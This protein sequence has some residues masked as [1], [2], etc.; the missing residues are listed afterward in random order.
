MTAAYSDKA[1]LRGEPSYVWRAGQERR[2]AM[3]LEAAGERATGRVL[4]NGCGV[5]MYLSRLAQRASLAAGI[6]YEHERALQARGLASGVACAAGEALPF[7]PDSFDLILSHEV[8]EHVQDDFRA[9][10]EMVR[11]LRPGGRLVLFVP[12]RGYPFETH[13][14]YWRGRYRFGNIPLVNYLPRRLRDKLAPHV[15]VYTRRDLEKRFAGLPVRIIRRTIIFGAYDNIIARFPALGRLVRSLLHF[16]ERTPLRIFGLSHFWV[17][18]K[19]DPV[20]ITPEAR[21]AMNPLG[22]WTRI[23]SIGL[24]V[25]GALLLMLALFGG[26]AANLALPL[27]IVVLGAVFILLAVVL[28]DTWRAAPW[29]YLPGCLLVPLGFIF[30]L[31]VATEDWNAWTYAWMLVVAGLGLGAAL[32]GRRFGFPLLVMQIGLGLA[33]GG[34]TFFALFGML[35]GG[36][37]IQ[38]TAPILLAVIGVALWRLRPDALLLKSARPGAQIGGIETAAPDQGALAEPLS[39]REIEVL[40]LIDQGLTNAAI[41]ERLVVAPST[42]KTHIN[43][44][45]GKLGVQT[46]VQALQKARELGL[47]ER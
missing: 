47:L 15:Q 16:L 5:G 30:L 24:V 19:T 34:V 45:Y 37:L 31:N 25:T 4:D 38:I 35:V 41:A 21:R 22:Q 13:G 8:L 3:L 20:D 23:V 36:M 7:L 46:R 27:L 32:V 17:L 18:E 6:E 42:I 28:A 40:R 14:V 2:L 39:G 33:A 26:K 9:A 43:N 11:V 12:N 10:A 44:I 29:L 1:A